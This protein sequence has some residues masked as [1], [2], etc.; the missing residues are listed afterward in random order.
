MAPLTAT[1]AIQNSFTLMVVSPT[2]SSTSYSLSSLQQVPQFPVDS[3]KATAWFP[4]PV[5]KWVTDAA[6]E[7]PLNQEVINGLLER[8]LPSSVIA[9]KGKTLGDI[10][11]PMIDEQDWECLIATL[12][13]SQPDLQPIPRCQTL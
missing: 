8:R 4:S 13:G 12:G 10:V 2:S 11:S 3:S 6:F 7:N 9:G 1:P 5:E